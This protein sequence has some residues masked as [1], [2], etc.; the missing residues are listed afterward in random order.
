MKLSG[1]LFAEKL[2]KIFDKLLLEE[3]LVAYLDD[4]LIISKTDED[5]LDTFAVLLHTFKTFNIKL[6]PDKISILKSEVKFLG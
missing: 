3:R 1:D 5:A 2:A 4:I 6:N